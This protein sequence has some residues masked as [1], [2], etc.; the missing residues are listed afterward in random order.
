ML[1]LSVISALGENNSLSFENFH[2]IHELKVTLPK[3]KN[4]P[5]VPALDHSCIF[6]FDF[7]KYFSAFCA[8][9]EDSL[10][11]CK[12]YFRPAFLD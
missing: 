3:L 6:F 1:N 12:G 9:Q 7:V 8:H 10:K 2:L 5:N 11:K 4:I